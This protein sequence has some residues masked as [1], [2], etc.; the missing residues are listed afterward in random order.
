M[1]VKT[2]A[3]GTFGQSGRARVHKGRNKT[4]GSRHDTTRPR[5]CHPPKESLLQ[6]VAEPDPERPRVGPHR[7]T[8][9]RGA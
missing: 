2:P 9:E 3:G 8:M 4:D 5:G 6:I 7:Q 1:A